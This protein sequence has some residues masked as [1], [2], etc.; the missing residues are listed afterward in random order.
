MD[1][2]DRAASTLDHEPDDAAPIVVAF[3]AYA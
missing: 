2:G 3:G 1:A